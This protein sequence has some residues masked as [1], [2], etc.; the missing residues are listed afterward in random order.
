M[1]YTKAIPH[2]ETKQ[3]YLTQLFGDDKERWLSYYVPL[4]AFHQNWENLEA[5]SFEANAYD[6]DFY[7]TMGWWEKIKTTE[8]SIPDQS[9]KAQK[10]LHEDAIA[11]LDDMMALC[12]ENDVEVVFFT[13]PWQGVFQHRDAIAEYAEQNGCAYL[14]LFEK[15]DEVGL[16]VKTDFMDEGHLNANGATKVANYL[17]A[18]LAENYEL[19]DMR[20]IENNIWEQALAR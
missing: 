15:M 6:N 19:T 9:S 17:G 14:N 4:S 2:S 5:R 12:K 13:T 8:I 3:E 20:T 10:N 18:Y 11:V 16:D 7:Q 1:L